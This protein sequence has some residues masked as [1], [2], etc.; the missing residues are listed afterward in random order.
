L[1]VQYFK[2]FFSG[3]ASVG[4]QQP[5][6]LVFKLAQRGHAVDVIAGDSNAYDERDEPPETQRF[7]GGGLVRVRRLRSPKGMRRSLTAR[8]STYATFALRAGASALTLARPDVVIGSIQPL[9]TGLAALASARLARAPFVLEIR[10]LWPDAL[11]AK[12]AITALQATPLHAMAYLLYH[13]AD[14]IVSLTPGIKRELEKKGIPSAKIDVLPNGF[15]PRLFHVDPTTIAQTRAHYG[16]GNT[17]V[18]LYTGTH[19]EVTAIDVIVR[20]AAALRQR[21]DIRIDLFG[22]GQTKA[23]AQALAT[24]LGLS[25]LHF[26]DPVPKTQIPAIIAAADVCL[27]TLFE[28]PLIHIYF[29]NKFMDYMGSGKAILAAM[30]GEQ[31]ELIT[32]HE[33]GRVVAAFD[34]HG[35]A[36]L[37]RE[38]A[39]DPDALKAYGARGAQLVQDH[40]LLDTILSHYVDVIEA[41][42]ANG[43]HHVATWEPFA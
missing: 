7:P 33:T 10:D 24:T 21:P 36:N 37:I 3:P 2:Q 11:Q 40:L 15:D 25:N 39:D 27:M 42:A 22:Q 18:A 13:G 32:R 30:G 23:N 12:G 8:L 17:F 14:R 6:E 26:H 19:T 34:H 38:G 29:E 16:W 28:S 31:A 9:F 41:T 1:R 35:L 20:A 43:V 5:R 4:T